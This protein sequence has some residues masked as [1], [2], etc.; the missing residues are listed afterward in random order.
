MVADGA[1]STA[2]RADGIPRLRGVVHTW[3][4]F[5]AVVAGIVLVALAEEGRPRLASW[6]YAAS[7]A[8]M[9]GASALH[10]RG[11]WRSAFVRTS[12]RR[13]DH[14]A[15]FIFI[16]G[17][18]TPF[19]LLAVQGPVG[20][21]LLAAVWTGAA[22]GLLLRLAWADAP[23]WL[24]AL[25]YVGLGWIGVLVLPQL[26]AAVGVA[27]SVLVTVG[28]ALYTLGALT[29]VLRRPNPAPTVFGYHEVFH[30]LVVA[31]ATVQ[32]VAV[33]VV[34]LRAG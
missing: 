10:H 17:S 5:A 6:L 34:V 3:S 16:A 24:A 8:T 12:I 18:Y 23:T 33:S 20:T 11:R 25:A 22:A 4:F 1:E 29:Y 26:F 31:A 32:Y 7:L 15:I 14:A 13:L 30:V 21:I 9:L 19:A 28:G 2:L 27:V